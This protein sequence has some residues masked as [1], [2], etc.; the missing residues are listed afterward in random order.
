MSRI[1]GVFLALVGLTA[2]AGGQ[3]YQPIPRRIPPAGIKLSAEQT[4][5]YAQRASGGWNVED[6]WRLR[7]RLARGG[8][9]P[10]DSLSL[11]W[12]RGQASAELAYL[13]A[14]SAVEYLASESGPRGLE[15][16]LDRWR[17]IGEF[18]E[19]FRRTFGY[20]TG[21]FETRWAEHVER[22]YGWVLMLEQTAIF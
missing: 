6:A 5:G 17:Q 19:A 3:D 20:A 1:F 13:L 4:E 2:A 7:V 12:P 22:R 18:E 11:E 16:F 8:A 15:V 10:L 21:T 9:P 14:G